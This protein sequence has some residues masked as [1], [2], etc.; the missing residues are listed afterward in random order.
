MESR[1][2]GDDRQSFSCGRQKCNVGTW[3]L[4]QVIISK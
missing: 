2:G 3:L 4:D 1:M